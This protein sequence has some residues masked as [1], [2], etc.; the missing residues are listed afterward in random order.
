MRRKKEIVNLL[1]SVSFRSTGKVLLSIERVCTCLRPSVRP[2]VRP[3][4]S[5]DNSI[6]VAIDYSRVSEKIDV[7]SRRNRLKLHKTE[8]GFTAITAK[9]R[10][11]Q[12]RIIQRRVNNVK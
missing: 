4:Y 7:F 11:D 1:H 5:F 9:K 6:P 2:S 12:E 8:L 10:A 3:L